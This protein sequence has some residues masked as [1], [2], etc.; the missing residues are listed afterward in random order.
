[1]RVSRMR[2]P[3]R[4]AAPR[5]GPRRQAR[6]PSGSLWRRRLRAQRAKTRAAPRQRALAAAA[7]CMPPA[8]GAHKRR[9]QTRARRAG[10][11]PSLQRARCRWPRR[12]GGGVAR[13]DSACAPPV[14]ALA[15]TLAPAQRMRRLRLPGTRARPRRMLA[16]AHTLLLDPT[17]TPAPT[18]DLTRGAARPPR[19]GAYC[20]PGLAERGGRKAL[21]A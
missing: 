20:L 1:M 13:A 10:A 19:R 4:L 21:Q 2:A 14:Q 18:L 12:A 15:W 6:L 17:L 3:R 8:K 16:S 5:Q 9:R 11:S 7:A